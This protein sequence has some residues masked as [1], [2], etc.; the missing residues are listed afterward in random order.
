MSRRLV[1][2]WRGALGGPVRPGAD[3]AKAPPVGGD[4]DG[5]PG[6]S[7]PGFVDLQVNGYGGVSFS[8]AGLT[9]AACEAACEAILREGACAC[10][11]PTV[12]TAPLA[13]YEA[14]LPVLADCIEA[15][16]HRLL[17]IHLEGPFISDEPGSVGAHPAA[18]VLQPSACAGG[19]RELLEHWQALARG[20]IR[21]LTIAPEVDGA[22]EL[23]AHARGLGMTISLGHMRPERGPLGRLA[24]C[25]ATLLTHL[26]NGCPRS[27]PR[28][29]NH[30]WPSLVEDRLTAM[31][32][33]DGQHLPDDLIATIVRAKGVGRVI[34]TSDAAPVAGLEDGQYECFGGQVRVEGRFV[35]TADGTCLAGSGSL[36]LACINHLAR[37]RVRPAD[38][39]SPTANSAPTTTGLLSADELVRVGFDNPL[40]A[41]GHDPA[42]V[43]ARL[44]SCVPAGGLVRYVDGAFRREGAWAS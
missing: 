12:I 41:I 8:D 32:I 14:V 33:S 27:L 11:L 3:S 9:R 34:V 13:T 6:V 21:L 18:H 19:G 43:R 35:R 31:I 23:C 24:A 42:V 38:D 29:D 5:A 28:H 26:G 39:V 15:T 36:M 44:M 1:R 22:A 7:L 10:I 30:M 37:V 4:S 17:G 2:P 16:P 40:R 20:H 25:G